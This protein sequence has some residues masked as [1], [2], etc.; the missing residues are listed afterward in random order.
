MRKRKEKAK[1]I[2]TLNAKQALKYKKDIEEYKRYSL[3]IRKFSDPLDVYAEIEIDG[4][5]NYMNAFLLMAKGNKRAKRSINYD[6]L[7]EVLTEIMKFYLLATN[8]IDIKLKVK[9]TYVSCNF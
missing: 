1:M 9:D 2:N 3:T 7:Q 6:S 5:D 8:D 4:N